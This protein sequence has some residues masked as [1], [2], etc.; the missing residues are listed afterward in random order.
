[1]QKKNPIYTG[2]N[3]FSLL[4]QYIEDGHFSRLIF[5]VDENTHEHCLPILLQ[6][7]EDLPP[8]EVLEIEAGEGSKDAEV[9]LQLW[10]ALS[11]LGADR[12]SLIINVGG[13]V[14]TDLGGF[15]AGT[16]MRGIPFVNIPTSLLAMVDAS[17]G[18]KTGVNLGGYKN[19]VGLFLNPEVVCVN[20]GF[21]ETLPLRERKS[22]FAEMLKHGL[23]SDYHY[24][25]ELLELDIEEDY[26]TEVMIERSIAI[27]QS[28]ID[29]DFRESGPRKALNFGHSIGH[30]IESLSL[31][32]ASPLLHGE[33]I[34]LGM[35][36][37]V[38]LSVQYCGFDPELAGEINS[39]L[40]K[41]YP[42]LVMPED[43]S[44]IVELIYGD[45]K[46]KSQQLNFSLLSKPGQ[47]EVN[48]KVEEKYI[49]EALKKVKNP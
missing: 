29:K 46:N 44:T 45:K 31:H 6:Q 48:V 14:V 42:E 30:A 19:R 33:A 49:I 36:A 5:L 2:E 23:I 20:V 18:G 40:K 9:L 12:Y 38:L 43:H 25:N 10:F 41:I 13:G 16:F 26:P 37:E 28:F 11:D 22:G 4:Q 34:I 24:F 7:L 39:K 35:M 32:S 3:S 17:N 1:M 15:L 21:L 27:K 8:T 47:C